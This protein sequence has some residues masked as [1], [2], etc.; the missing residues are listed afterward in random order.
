MG[1][2]LTELC[3]PLHPSHPNHC[4]LVLQV[5]EVSRFPFIVKAIPVGV[6]STQAQQTSSGF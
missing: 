6:G 1:S 5:A 3:Q 4:S 2:V